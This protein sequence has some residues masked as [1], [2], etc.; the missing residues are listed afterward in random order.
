MQRDEDAGWSEKPQGAFRLRYPEDELRHGWLALLLDAYAIIDRGIARAIESETRK[1]H[2]GLACIKGCAACCRT[3]RDI[4]LYPLEMVGI[5]W[6]CVEKMDPAVREILKGQLSRFTVGGTCPFLIDSS[7]SI[8]PMRPVACRQFNVFGNA[9]A[10]GEDPFHT[11]RKDVLTPLKEYVEKAFVV[12]MPFYGI[13]KEADKLRAARQG[14]LHSQ[15]TNLKSYNWRA[16]RKRMDD[17]D[18]GSL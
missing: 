16:L 14:L 8:H 4:P 1:R 17:F 9:C 12:M 18:A 3:H 11:R 6:F 2:V 13:T 15:A 10:E 5:Y 7:C